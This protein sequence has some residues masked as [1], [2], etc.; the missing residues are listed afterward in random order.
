MEL[1]IVCTAFERPA[2]LMTQLCSFAAQTLQNFNI[3]VFHDGYNSAIESVVNEFRNIYPQIQIKYRFSDNRYNDYGHSL[4]E[5]ALLDATSEF[6]LLT[7]DDNY[8]TPNFLEELMPALKSR[9]YDIRYCNM[10]HC[11]K[12]YRSHSPLGYHP[13]YTQMKLG[14]IDIGS[15]IFNTR[16]GQKAK[17]SDRSFD[18]DGLFLERMIANG[19]RSYKSD[20]FLFVHN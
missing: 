7:N 10:I 3:V 6:L 5:V 1:E 14:W 15:F 19:A 18:A 16:K 2:A 17:F 4:R 11:H 8:Y 9:V 13:L 12:K 20:K